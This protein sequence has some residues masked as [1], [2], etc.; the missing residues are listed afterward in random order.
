MLI[1]SNVSIAADDF[2]N[3][4]IHISVDESLKYLKVLKIFR[5]EGKLVYISYFSTLFLPWSFLNVVS[6]RCVCIYEGVNPFPHT[7]ILQQTFD[8]K[9]P[10]TSINVGKITEQ[11]WKYCGKRRNC[12]C[13]AI[14][15]FVTMFS[16]RRRKASA[17]RKELNWYNLEVATST[18]LY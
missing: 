17:F 16:K 6:W 11:N 4:F 8:A 13:W 10:K 14:S 9:T 15:T 7:T 3:I 18:N 2:V 12:S 5:Q 1:L